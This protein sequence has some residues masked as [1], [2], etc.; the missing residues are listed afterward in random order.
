M[1]E[2]DVLT[3]DLMSW[4]LKITCLK[5]LHVTLWVYAYGR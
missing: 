5:T 2:P 1:R 3:I 4:F